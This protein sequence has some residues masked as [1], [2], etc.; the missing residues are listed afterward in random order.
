MIAYFKHTNGE[1]FTLAGEDYI[2]FFH[3]IDNKAFTGKITTTDSQ[4]LV[5]KSTMMAGLYTQSDNLD[6]TYKNIPTI[7]PYYSNTFDLLN[8][9]GVISYIGALDANNLI[10]FKSLILGNPTIFT[11][12]SDCHYYGFISNLEDSSTSVP[13]KTDYSGHISPFSVSNYWSF[14]D[15]MT[16]GVVVVDTSENFKYVCSDGENDYILTASFATDD[17]LTLL[18]T[19]PNLV[20]DI[21]SPDHN[22]PNFTYSVHHDV[23]N[24]KFLFVKLSAIEVYDA[25]TYGGCNNLI[26][27]DKIALPPS[28]FKWYI[29]NTLDLAPNDTTV[30][31][32]SK[33]S[34][35][36]PT[37]T[38]FI[39]FGKNLRTYI[40]SSTLQ[41]F[42]KYST[43]IYQS[44]DLPAYDINNVLAV[45]IRTVDDYI[46][47]LHG[48]DQL[49]VSFFDPSE[50]DI[51]VTTKDILSIKYN[52]TMGVQFS[53]MDS[54]MFYIQSP[55]EYHARYITNPTY[56]SGRL[57]QCNFPYPY[58]AIWNTTIE[59]YNRIPQQWNT[60]TTKSNNYNNIVSAHAFAN[61]KMYM[62]HHNIGRIF[63]LH[64]PANDRY[65]PFIPL[66]LVKYQDRVECGQSSLG[67]YINSELTNVVKDISNIYI[68]TFSS[69]TLSEHQILPVPLD[70]INPSSKN[71][72]V[73]GN[74]TM[75]VIS[76]QRIS[77]NIVNLQANL[78]P[79]D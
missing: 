55:T 4:E 34:L 51:V 45:D 28:K 38:K 23:E 54:N 20:F 11:Y 52:D 22:S 25:I 19:K 42:N 8:K 31:W 76:L 69:F 78:L 35:Y 61:N 3:I 29:W 71:L 74:E 30:T 68:N 64:Q 56:P 12:T 43:T 66:N 50:S 47:I 70:I 36:N 60:S 33:Y 77:S 7:L 53:D 2:G 44:I 15:N 58:H 5:A 32:N 9:Q 73:H 59:T 65:Y 18:F 63:A 40:S 72:N 79:S 39:K 67:L 1:S 6:T 46:I 14:L 27:I 57:D 41:L 62:I 16:T 13:C 24:S 48:T 17:P 75:N 49:K 37:A 10:C 21:N 26:L